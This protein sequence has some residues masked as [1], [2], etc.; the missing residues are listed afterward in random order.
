MQEVDVIIPAYKPGAEFIELIDKLEHQSIPVHQILIFNTEQKYWEALQYDHPRRKRYENVRMWHIS[1]KEFDHGRTRREAVKKSQTPVFVMM[2]QDAMPSDEFLLER[3]IAPLSDRDV[4]VSYARQLPRKEAGA[5]ERFTREFNYPDQSCIK[6]KADLDEMGIKTFF[7]SNVCA[8]Y[9]RDIYE[10]Q[11]G[12]IKHAIFNE[13]M[14]YAAGCIR[15]GYKIA[16][17][18]EAKVIHSHQYTNKEQ[19]RRNFDLGVSQ[20]EHPEVF[21]SVPAESE[22]IRLV[23]RTAEYLKKEG[24]GR[25]I[26]PMCVTSAYKFFGYKLGKNYKRLSFRRILK[27]TMNRTY[28]ESMRF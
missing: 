4:A 14:I 19:F 21:E 5:V 3:L 26:L 28:W 22:G 27:Y 13:D 17:T 9:R 10:K 15:A 16:Y 7:C 18:A 1:K 25:L 2:T 23:K 8:A 12:F 6:S 11:G 24:E 20:A